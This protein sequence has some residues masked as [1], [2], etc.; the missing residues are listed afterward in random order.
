MNDFFCSFHLQL[1][2]I[3]LLSFK[4]SPTT[5]K[6]VGDSTSKPEGWNE[7]SRSYQNRIGAC[8][9]HGTARLVDTTNSRYPFDDNSFVHDNGTGG[10]SILR[11]IKQNFPSTKILATDISPGML[12]LIDALHLPGVTTQL[13]DACDLSGI[14][15][16]TFTHSLTSFMN[17][18][19]PDMLATVHAMYRTLKPGGIAGFAI[20]GGGTDVDTIHNSAC[21][22][23]DPSYKRIDTYPRGSWSGEEEQ[24]DAMM[25]AGFKDIEILSLYMPF[26]F[27]CAE[28]FCEW[29]F[30]N[31]GNPVAKKFIDDWKE[32]GEGSLEELEK[33]AGD[34]VR[35]GFDDGKSMKMEAVLA[36]GRK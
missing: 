9:M 13:E 7:F 1:S 15:D 20:W 10:G 23:L 28:E 8:T 32:H 5:T 31:H 11:N 3:P 12:G 4:M 24:R 33:V 14:S 6:Q 26:K 22:R 35:K 27:E 36:W 25:K 17:Q 34:V 30:G 18:F 2:Q 29:W 16:G 19:T 21:T